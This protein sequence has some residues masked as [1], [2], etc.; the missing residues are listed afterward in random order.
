MKEF[1]NQTNKQTKSDYYK[2]YY[3]KNKEIMKEKARD[4]SREIY[5][6]NNREQKLIKVAT[7]LKF[8]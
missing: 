3:E 6:P 7:Y 1:R 4:Y 2:I 8:S 5:Y